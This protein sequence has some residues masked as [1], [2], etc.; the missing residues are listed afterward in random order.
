[1]SSVSIQ[2]GKK[3]RSGGKLQSTEQYQRIQD[4]GI[5]GDLHTAALVG[6]N[7]SI[8]F[9]CFPNFDSP[10]IFA[11]LLDRKKGGHF[12][13]APLEE[14]PTSKQIYLT[15]SNIL[16]SRFFFDNCI[17]EISDY[18][19]IESEQDTH[20]LVRRAKSI[21]GGL[22]YRMVCAPR[23]N[24]ARTRHR[25]E[26]NDGVVTFIPEDPAFPPLRLRSSVPVELVDG[27][28]T[29]EFTLEQGET[30]SF[31]L[32]GVVPGKESLS[33]S[34]DYIPG[35]FKDT[36]N[37][38]RAWV[39]RSHY[40]GR[41]RETVN[42]SALVLKLLTFKP[43]GA[44]VAAPTFGLPEVLGGERNWDYRY[45]WIR[46]ASFTLYALIRLGYTDE[47]R[48]FMGWIEQRCKESAPD[49]T[50][51]IMYS[52][53]GRHDLT[54][55]ILD[56]FEG[57]KH[58]SPVR[59]GNGAFRQLQLD[60][61]GELMDSVYLYDKFGEPISYDL[62]KNLLRLMDWLCDNWRQPDD[63]IWEVRGG[64]QKFLHS[65]V[66]S[67]VAFDRASRLATRRS[68]PA[69][70]DQWRKCRD[71]IYHDVFENFWNPER[72]AFMQYK[73]ANALDASALLMPLMKFIGAQDP[74]WLSTLHQ[75]E[76]H[77]VADSLVYRYRIGKGAVDG[78]VG[79]EGTFNMCS[80]WYVECLSRAG[81]IEQAR[82][83]F[84]KMLGYS[85][86]LGLYSEELGPRTEYLGNFP[87]AFTHL[88]L[89]S[90]A[91]DVDRRLSEAGQR[92]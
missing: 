48:Q 6:R 73:G 78:L 24:Y 12:V 5:I 49:K 9:M 26:I 66:M 70:L 52:I 90:A 35:S 13:V 75:I 71:E 41:W 32:E 43:T 29:A 88:G 37:F 79:Q 62:W 86:H 46:D 1:M 91:F 18:M 44:I 54:E 83:F 21:L 64:R 59:I 45:T 61:Y 81:D 27:D 50:L 3:S 25:T 57:Y 7:G 92:G 22:K 65:R 77:L 56:N 33:A 76:K 80:F 47:A 4:Y 74:R 60:T 17:A 14:S 28:A 8:D 82:F 87:Q 23:F 63:G 38:W 31:I 39:G 42:R 67:W 51:Q 89:I 15:D 34:P 10:S 40:R 69:P 30:A 19:P 53:D 11:A 55:T 58:S 2:T 85:N 72:Q 36:L 20:D 84:E 68:F 16:L